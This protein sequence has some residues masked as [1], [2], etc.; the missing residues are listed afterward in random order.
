MTKVSE[1]LR[2]ARISVRE[3][4]SVNDVSVFKDVLMGVAAVAGYKVL[5]GGCRRDEESL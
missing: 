2:E 1:K 5:K 3:G 4:A